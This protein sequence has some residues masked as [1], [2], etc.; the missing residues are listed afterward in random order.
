[1][2]REII[3]G[4]IPKILWMGFQRGLDLLY[5]RKCILCHQLPDDKGERFERLGLCSM[6][7][8]SDHAF[9]P[10]HF[11]KENGREIPEWIH[12]SFAYLE[13]LRF[14]LAELKYE[15]KREYGHFF[16]G[17]MAEEG[18]ELR[19]KGFDYI[20]AVP[21]AEGREKKR[22]YNQARLMAEVISATWEIPLVD[23]LVR[24]RETPPQKDLGE[25][26]RRSNVQG[27]FSLSPG[28]DLRMLK[29][30]R[31]LLIDDIFTSGATMESCRE[32]ILKAEPTALVFGWTFSA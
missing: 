2:N 4:R 22:G 19:K 8:P 27:A 12:V 25:E 18:E 24:T 15:G 26:L 31:I 9:D 30:R 28:V 17:W 11:K 3:E 1:M 16:G 21:L 14:N 29:G 6:C 5:P 13:Q 10:V 32:T 7:L 20:A 23:L